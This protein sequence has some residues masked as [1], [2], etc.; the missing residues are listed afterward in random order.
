MQ[1]SRGEKLECFILNLFVF[2]FHALFRIHV[3]IVSNPT[4]GDVQSWKDYICHVIGAKVKKKKK[5]KKKGLFIL[6]SGLL[7]DLF[8]MHNGTNSI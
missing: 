1:R 4:Q 6:L 2:K 5:R 7:E 3:L 8:E